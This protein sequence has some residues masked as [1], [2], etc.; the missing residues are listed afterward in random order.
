M[1]DTV[2]AAAPG[3]LV[4]IPAEPEAQP[5]EPSTASHSELP[6]ERLGRLAELAA[7]ALELA[8]P[9]EAT[10][11]VLAEQALADVWAAVDAS[12]SRAAKAA[13]R[14]DWARF[15]TWTTE[16][17]F[18]PL[19]APGL[20]VAHYVTGVP[21]FPP[22]DQ[23]GLLPFPLQTLTPHSLSRRVQDLLAGD[24]G[25]HRHLPGERAEDVETEGPAE[26]P[27][28]VRPA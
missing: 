2:L 5:S 17:G 19:P 25:A 23:W 21:L 4:D 18:A 10:A 11:P 6:S 16:R 22:I 13:Y 14:S 7:A 27:A 26:V 20:V 1:T 3:H 28:G 9:T 8:T 15:T 12:T 24:L